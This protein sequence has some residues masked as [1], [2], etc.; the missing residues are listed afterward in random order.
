[1]E[2]VEKNSANNAQILLMAFSYFITI[3]PGNLQKYLS[4]WVSWDFS[5]SILW[6]NFPEQGK[7]NDSTEFLSKYKGFSL[8][9]LWELFKSIRKKFN[10]RLSKLFIGSF[11]NKIF[12]LRLF[13]LFVFTI[14]LPSHKICKK[15]SNPQARISNF[16]RLTWFEFNATCLWF[17]SSATE[18]IFSRKTILQF[19]L[20]LSRSKVHK[21][22]LKLSFLL[23]F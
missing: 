20:R 3:P 17:P 4:Y 15:F 14:F 8:K 6:W 16:L 7:I 9:T 10:F 23:C 11:N 18:K 12:P 19:S 5:S 13:V 1:M 2:S 22:T 21:S